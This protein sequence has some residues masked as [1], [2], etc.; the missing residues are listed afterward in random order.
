[1][2][3]IR[4]PVLMLMFVA[5]PV[6]LADDQ[7]PAGMDTSNDTA[8]PTDWMYQLM[9]AE[10][11]YDRG[12]YELALGTYVH[13]ALQTKQAD[14]AERATDLA[15]NLQ[16]V[17]T[18]LEMSTIW[19]NQAPES[20]RAQSTL[21]ALL[22]TQGHAE[23]A[24]LYIDRMARISSAESLAHIQLLYD[25]L[26]DIDF[27]SNLLLSLEIAHTNHPNRE[28]TQIALTHLY[29]LEQRVDDALAVSSTAIANNAP[30]TTLIILH[31][32]ALRMDNQ[33]LQARLFIEEALAS[34]PKS[35]DIR[36][37]YADILA[38]IFND[39]KA[40]QAQITLLLGYDEVS[41][42]ILADAAYLALDMEWL[43]A[44]K[45]VLERLKEYPEKQELAYFFMGSIAEIEGK[46]QLAMDY[47]EQVPRGP[48]QVMSFT[49]SAN[50]AIQLGDHDRALSVL[51]Q[52]RPETYEDYKLVA[53]LR[54]DAY[55]REEAFPR[56]LDVL[57]EAVDILPADTDIRYIR[58]LLADKLGDLEMAERDL[59]HI[60]QL[61]PNHVEALN[62]L[63]YILADKTQ[64]YEEAL[65][66][67]E[68]ANTLQPN[69]AGILDS[70]GWV[71]YKMG[72][73]DLAR[74]HLADAYSLR[75]DGMI[76]AHYGEVLWAQGNKRLA[77]TIWLD[78][79]RIAPND[80]LLI[81]TLNF[82]IPEWA[83]AFNTEG[84]LGYTPAE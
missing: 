36:L 20:M 12:E 65:T 31:S 25:E 13:L 16:D 48:L 28:G 32:E 64:R 14:I 45:P 23:E 63:G 76:G 74:Q 55:S 40:S 77:S 33:V 11:A 67:I 49:H 43:D 9:A 56:A 59:N 79:L 54:V 34:Q 52:A 60:I 27:R 2:K 71:H 44:A 47:F 29:L 26:T 1:M 62:A 38:T 68:K 39:P 50:I 22:L 81:Q 17:T 72:N 57:T 19:A 37:Y 15:V 42:E 69:N 4:I 24:A 7:I 66:L 58:G 70:L 75:P 10:M 51:E 80:E 73:L 61:E 21:T 8:I 18:A 78:T 46:Y 83:T 3:Y 84:H 82:H 6:C 35:H 30:S 41:E 53:L 5:S